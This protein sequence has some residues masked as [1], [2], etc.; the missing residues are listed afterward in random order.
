MIFSDFHTQLMR[1][2]V[3]QYL[4]DY[5]TLNDYGAKNNLAERIV[6]AIRLSGGRFLNNDNGTWNGLSSKDAKEKVQQAFRSARKAP[7][8]RKIADEF[9]VGEDSHAVERLELLEESKEHQE[10]DDLDFSVSLSLSSVGLDTCR[11]RSNTSGAS[12]YF[13]TNS[14]DTTQL[15]MMSIGTFSH[16]DFNVSSSMGTQ[17]CSSRLNASGTSS[18]PQTKRH[19]EAM[20]IASFSHVHFTISSSTQA[21]R[22]RSTPRGTS[23]YTQ[24]SSHNDLEAMSIVHSSKSPHTTVRKN[25]FAPSSSHGRKRRGYPPLLTTIAVTPMSFSCSVSSLTGSNLSDT[26]ESLPMPATWPPLGKNSFIEACVKGDEVDV[27]FLLDKGMN[28]NLE[29]IDSGFAGLHLPVCIKTILLSSC[30]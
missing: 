4:N 18:Y 20:S 17:A 8:D 23:S 30:C 14:Y 19:L 16:S 24:M 9:E 29:N 13:Q 2:L 1:K 22:S 28:V 3:K 15:E 11:T 21:W 27:H 26:Y 10:A 12:S 25:K 7:S 6:Q 5:G